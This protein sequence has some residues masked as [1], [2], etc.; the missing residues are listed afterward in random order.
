MCQ[1]KSDSL[2]TLAEGAKQYWQAAY[3]RLRML[4][5]EEYAREPHTIPLSH[6][7]KFSDEM[8]KLVKWVVGDDNPEIMKRIDIALNHSKQALRAYKEAQQAGQKP[9][10]TQLGNPDS[11][12]E[13]DSDET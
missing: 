2:I 4:Y 8:F 6:A 11:V 7:Q 12:N 10:L 3:K 5:P 13:E 9:D 1:S